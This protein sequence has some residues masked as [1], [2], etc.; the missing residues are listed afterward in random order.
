MQRKKVP[1]IGIKTWGGR[2]LRGLVTPLEIALPYL[3]PVWAYQREARRRLV[4]PIYHAEASAQAE[5][6]ATATTCSKASECKQ[7]KRCRCGLGDSGS[8]RNDTRSNHRHL[9]CSQSLIPNSKVIEC[10]CTGILRRT[11]AFKPAVKLKTRQSLFQS[12]TSQSVRRNALTIKIRRECLS[13]ES[14]RDIHT[15][16]IGGQSA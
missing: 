5:A 16:T 14:Q 11:Y 2:A 15:G 4:T 1:P 10:L 8:L 12:I 6:L 7:R 3:R 13:F 9:V